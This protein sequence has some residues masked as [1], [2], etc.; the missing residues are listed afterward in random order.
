MGI[1]SFYFYYN[2]PEQVATHWNIAGEPD[3]WS[4][5]LSGAF[6][7]PL[8][9]L[10]MY[11]LFFILPYLDPRKN[12]Y[13][14]FRKIY[15]FFKGIMI[16]FMVFIF[17]LMGF[18]NLDYNINIELWMPITIGVLFMLI[19]NY[20]G[21]IK[22]NWFLGIKTPWT[23]SNEEVWNRTHR[24]SGRMFILS[25]F[26]MILTGFS[27]VSLKLPLF[28]V[29]IAIII[30]GTMGYSYLAYRKEEKKN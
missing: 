10:G 13:D 29:A 5:K 3:N 8:I 26:L 25:G 24:F 27:P 17:A 16:F 2:F 28:I 1:L 19:G 18:S 14:Q 12:R 11:L 23:L 20:M 4:S 21:K 22:P 15:H 7:F 9:V 30:L 6:V